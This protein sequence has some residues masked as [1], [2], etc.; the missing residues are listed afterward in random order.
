MLSSGNSRQG[1]KFFIHKCKQRLTRLTQVAIRMR[2]LGR[3]RNIA[4]MHVC[5]SII[6]ARAPVHQQSLN[7]GTLSIRCCP[8]VGASLLFL[9]VSASIR[10]KT[11]PHTW[12]VPVTLNPRFGVLPSGT[13]SGT[14]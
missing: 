12:I 10:S 11:Q 2:R 1:P 7:D 13:S 6:C 9:G 5:I 4:G 8:G 14:D 3:A